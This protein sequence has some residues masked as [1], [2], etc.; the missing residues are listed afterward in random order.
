MTIKQLHKFRILQLLRHILIQSALNRL[1]NENKSINNERKLGLKKY[2]ILLILLLLISIL[3]YRHTIQFII[4][5]IDQTRQ[6]LENNYLQEI[7]RVYLKNT[8]NVIKILF[9]FLTTLAL[10]VMD[11]STRHLLL[12]FFGFSANICE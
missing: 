3:I 10:F 7:T 11:S 1:T 4:Q 5:P 6:I 8:E 2:I 9:Y 12:N